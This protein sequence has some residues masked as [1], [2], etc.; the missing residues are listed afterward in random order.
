MCVC[1]REREREREIS[2]VCVCVYGCLRVG[3][4]RCLCLHLRHHPCVTGEERRV[5]RCF[6]IRILMTIS[7]SLCW[8]Q[9]GKS[10]PYLKILR[11]L[12]DGQTEAVYTTETISNTLNPEWK[13]FT[14]TI[15]ELCNGNLDA[16]LLIECWDYDAGS[17][18]IGAR[19][20]GYN[21]GDDQ[22]G[23]KTVT[24]RQLINEKE[25]QLDDYKERKTK[26]DPGKLVW[27]SK[28]FLEKRVQAPSFMDYFRGGYEMKVSVAIDFTGSNGDPKS[29]SSLHYIQGPKP[30]GYQQA[31]A[32]VLEILLEYDSDDTVDLMG[33]G[34]LARKRQVSHCFPL[35]EG[36]YSVKGGVQGV[37]GAY[38]DA[39]SKIGLSGPTN[40]AE[41]I[42]HVVSK[43]QAS[44]GVESKEYNVLLILT[45]GAITDTKATA[46]EIV[47]SSELPM[48][49]IIVGI[50]PGN[51]GEMKK[52]DG[53]D[54]SLQS[55]RG[56]KASRDI[57]QFV[58]FREFDGL[59]DDAGD[60]LSAHVLAELPDQF[61]QFMSKWKIQPG[62]DWSERY[63]MP[64]GDWYA[65]S[66]VASRDLDFD[67]VA[68]SDALAGKMASALLLNSGVDEDRDATPDTAIYP[69]GF[70][71]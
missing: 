5:Y 63:I 68:A 47:H 6:L 36:D 32:S 2:R 62:G 60:Q 54:A 52:M 37:L 38:K 10:D 39:L 33:F 21:D 43:V 13:S 14:K 59:G 55:M 25:L 18:G 19:A 12:K 58:P 41:V 31:L 64:E 20:T 61:L 27:E 26:I 7:S 46:S 65:Q 35:T 11:P 45:D 22:I 29:K 49:I 16:P 34:G 71:A 56:T 44:G 15:L 24:V 30:N 40:F 17:F 69:E 23:L 1:E 28:L 3:V 4:C 67:P 42:R 51:F 66:K 9:G 48:S 70:E 8:A 53:D 57:V 50:G